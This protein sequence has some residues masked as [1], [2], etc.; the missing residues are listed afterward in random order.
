MDDLK[1]TEY[2]I[3]GIIGEDSSVIET[4]K[5]QYLDE[6]YNIPFWNG[7]DVFNDISFISSLKED[8]SSIVEIDHTTAML[9]S[10]NTGLSLSEVASQIRNGLNTD[11]SK[12]STFIYSEE[13][14]PIVE[15]H[16]GNDPGYVYIIPGEIL[17]NYINEHQNM[18]IDYCVSQLLE[19]HNIEPENIYVLLPKESTIEECN[20]LNEMTNFNQILN[21]ALFLKES[22]N[23]NLCTE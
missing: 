1:Q 2:L 9:V 21:Q 3:N 16:L 7:K 15:T 17:H 23:I 19:Y 11:E 10:R 22:L 8:F 4:V 13:N 5:K 6:S 14:I 20:D 18:N 12:L